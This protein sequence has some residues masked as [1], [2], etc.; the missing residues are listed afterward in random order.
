MRRTLVLVALL[1]TAVGPLLPL[2]AQG[3]RDRGLVEV[4]PPA[5]RGGFFITGGIGAGGEQFK[6]EDE[7]DYSE[8][9]TKPTIMLRLGGTPSAN[10]R[11]GA[12]LFGWGSDEAEGFESFTAGLV[13]VQYFP[14]KD[15]GLFFKGGAGIA[16]SGFD[17]DDPFERSNDETGFAWSVGAGYDFQ[18]TRKF[19]I[20]PSIDFYRASFTMRDQ[21]TLNERVLN[22]GV[23]FTFQTGGLGR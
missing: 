23:Q 4:A 10:F 22:I 19:G 13:S 17:P 18:L 12:E 6:F 5:T 3:R 2:A 7:S 21:P 14:I 1:S 8:T 15:Q 11:V 9:L 16:E 20:G